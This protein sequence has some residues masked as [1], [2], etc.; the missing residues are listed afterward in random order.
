MNRTESGD[1]GTYFTTSPSHLPWPG[2]KPSSHP[3]S[4]WREPDD[5]VT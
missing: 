5:H 4:A 3:S 1:D 2:A